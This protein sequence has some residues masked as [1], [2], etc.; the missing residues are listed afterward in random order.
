MMT[1]SGVAKTGQVFSAHSSLLCFTVFLVLKIGYQWNRSWWLI[2]LPLWIFHIIVARGRFSL[3]APAPPHDRH[4]APCHAVFAIPLLI[5]F[6]ILLCIYLDS[7]FG[8]GII[9][10]SLKLVFL[11]LIIFEILVLVDNFRM[12]RALM[13]TDEESMTDEAIWETL[14]HF[15]VAVSMVFFIA[16]TMFTLLKLNGD[17]SSLGWW[18]LFINYGIAEC[19]AFLVCTKWSNHL[20]HREHQIS[21][22]TPSV[23]RRDT[24][25]VHQEGMCGLQDI[26]GHIIKLPVVAF[27]ILLCMHL[28]GTPKAARDI[29]IAVIFIPIFIVQGIAVLLSFLR[30]LEKII[31]IL[32]NGTSL[33]WF[34]MIVNKG[35]IC[36]SFLH[37]GSRLLGWWSIDERSREEQARLL[38]SQTS[39]YNTFCTFPPEAVK[40]MSKKELAEEIWR[41]QAALG[42]QTEITNYSQEEYGRLKNEKLLCRICFEGEIGIVLLPCRHR[43]LCGSC[44]ERCKKCPICRVLIMERMPVY[45]G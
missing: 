28:E 4:W 27:Q 14:P 8:H 11:P 1:W 6:E 15:W 25:E 24:H 23:V 13:P 29:P 40:K 41:L 39:G 5:A 19:F 3:P 36:F 10:L 18:D 31:H 43:V 20:I 33:G 16:A 7:R 9:L 35:R 32:H 37:R 12:C 45:D 30:L 22:A 34:F 38:H 42:E 21:G 26:G 2:F 17:V 44:A